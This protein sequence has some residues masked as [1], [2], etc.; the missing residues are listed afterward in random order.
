MV[1]ASLVFDAVVAVSIA[2][3]AVFAIAEL[4]LMA[5][6]RRTQ[7]L[8][9]MVLQVS[10]PEMSE[11]YRKVMFQE[12]KNRKEAEEKCGYVALDTISTYYTGIGTLIRRRLVDADLAF[13]FMW[14]YPVWEHL[15]P[16]LVESPIRYG[17]IEWWQDLE[18]AAELDRAYKE[19]R[20]SELLK[21]RAREKRSA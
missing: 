6:D 12:F 9:G 16:W 14:I 1:D 3:G 18:Y 10:S 4:R 11:N 20:A 17:P 15:K 2:A 7:L 21:R 13:D 19:K 8:V 5:R